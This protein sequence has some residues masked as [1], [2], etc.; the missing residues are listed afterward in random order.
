MTWVAI[1]YLVAGIVC[2]D[3]V[4]K[5]AEND[6]RARGRWSKAWL[7]LFAILCWGPLYV[8]WIL[9]RIFKAIFKRK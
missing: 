9:S 5:L 4:L 7:Y 3:Q 6:G 1:V 8:A 2:A